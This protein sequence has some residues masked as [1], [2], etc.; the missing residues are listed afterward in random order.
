M[1]AFVFHLF[2]KE[3]VS[4]VK[5]PETLSHIANAAMKRFIIELGVPNLLNF[6]SEQLLG[7]SSALLSFFLKC[8]RTVVDKLLTELT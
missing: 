5:V 7:L 6:I 2:L 1:L 3:F 8:Y 4:A